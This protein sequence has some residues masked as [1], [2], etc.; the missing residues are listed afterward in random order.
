M[1]GAMVKL[2]KFKASAVDMSEWPDSRSG[3]LPQRRERGCS[4]DRLVRP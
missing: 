4:C 3:R 1:D 2:R